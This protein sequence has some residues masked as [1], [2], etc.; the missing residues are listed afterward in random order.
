MLRPPPHV[1]DADRVGRLYF[2]APG[3]D[4]EKLAVRE[5]SFRRFTELRDGA[6]SLVEVAAMED[7][8]LPVGVGT[9]ARAV[10]AAFVSANFWPLLGVRPALGRFFAAD[11]DRPPDGAALA[12]LSYAYWRDVLNADATVLGR[13]LDMGA[14]RFTVIGVAPEDFNGVKLRPWMC[15]SR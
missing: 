5:M 10:H 1:R 8:D 9:D 14:R 15:G 13:Q 11:E 6:A 7:Q 12:V 3:E 2:S 4:R